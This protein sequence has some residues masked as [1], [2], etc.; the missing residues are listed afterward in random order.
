MARGRPRNLQHPVSRGCD[1]LVDVR[2]DTLPQDRS[3]SQIGGRL[4]CT[5]FGA[6]GSV[7]IMPNWHDRQNAS[8][9]FAKGW[10]R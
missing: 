1:R 6:A 4:V 8:V 10:Q 9:P 3:W 7:N 5:E 2:L